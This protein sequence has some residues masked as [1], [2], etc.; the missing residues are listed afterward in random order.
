[1]PLFRNEI[2]NTIEIKDYNIALVSNDLYIYNNILNHLTKNE[3]KILTP[4]FLDDA[5][6]KK[7]GIIFSYLFL[8]PEI[9]VLN[10]KKLL[11][12]ASISGCLNNLKLIFENKS[13]IN[14]ESIKEAL[15][16]SS[17][18]LKIDIVNF[19]LQST[20]DKD[21]IYEVFE[22][23]CKS[24]VTAFFKSDEYLFFITSL[25]HKINV[26]K[27]N[28]NFKRLFDPN[29]IIFYDKNLSEKIKQT[30]NIANF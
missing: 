20:K 18:E 10:S 26:E 23:L 24:Y 25:I 6:S 7:D 22:I 13:L 4:V 15:L 3:I 11:Y 21:V 14:E 8:H 9:D 19:L 1:M 2:K 29:D 28:F 30:L 17:E 5:V 27:L 12:S 16:A